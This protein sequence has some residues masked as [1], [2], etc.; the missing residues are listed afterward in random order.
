MKTEQMTKLLK[1]YYSLL[2]T[3]GYEPIKV[4][5]KDLPIEEIKYNKHMLNH[6]CW[7]CQEAQQYVTENSEKT[8]RWLGFIQGVIWTSG[9]F[10]IDDMRDHNR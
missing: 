2:E 1:H 9:I 10:T 5:G 7:M 6:I 4:E 3:K 8:N